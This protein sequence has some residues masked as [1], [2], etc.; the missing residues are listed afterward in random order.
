[1]GDEQAVVSG[2]LQRGWAVSPGDRFRIASPAGIR[3]AIS[4]LEL[5]SRTGWRKRCPTASFS[6]PSAPTEAAPDRGRQRVLRPN[7]SGWR[8]ATC[9]RG[10]RLAGEDVE[11][12]ADGLVPIGGVRDGQVVLDVIAVPAAVSFLHHVAGIGQIAD[13][14]VGTALGDPEGAGDLAQAH[15][16]IVGDAQEGPPVVGEEVPL[17][18]RSER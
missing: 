17:G 13:D 15:L 10:R 12:L 1:M 4:T 3:I 16:R 9:P 14:A 5:T 11:D 18:H 7:L 8:D 6:D 2:L